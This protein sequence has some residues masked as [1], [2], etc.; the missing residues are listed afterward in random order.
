MVD[1]CPDMVPCPEAALDPDLLNLRKALRLSDAAYQAIAALPI[2][3]FQ[4]V[5]GAAMAL[6]SAKD[7]LTSAQQGH[8]RPPREA[9]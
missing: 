3:K 4:G 5:W 7:L 2:G 6:K 8:P 1:Y 9:P